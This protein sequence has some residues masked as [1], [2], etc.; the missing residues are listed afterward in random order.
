MRGEEG[1][2]GRF[3]EANAQ[4]RSTACRLNTSAHVLLFTPLPTLPFPLSSTS[5]PQ[6]FALHASPSLL[7]HQTHH[8]VKMS[9]HMRGQRWSRRSRHLLLLLLGRQHAALE[10]LDLPRA[11]L[12]KLRDLGLDAVLLATAIGP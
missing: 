9:S 2:E 5:F 12:D 6:T 10:L 11:R 1:A 7:P 3:Q 4:E 8:T